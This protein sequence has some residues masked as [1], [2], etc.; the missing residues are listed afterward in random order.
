MSAQVTNSARG[1]Y[2]YPN[3]RPFEISVL[4]RIRHQ[5]WWRARVGKFRIGALVGPLAV[6]Q[7]AN[8]CYYLYIFRRN[9][10]YVFLNYYDS[11]WFVFLLID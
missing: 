5:G 11:L 6:L 10:L 1:Y 2:G 9:A 8:S 4:Q 7:L 3:Y